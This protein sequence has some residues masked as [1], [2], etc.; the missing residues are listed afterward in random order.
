MSIIC[1]V[2]PYKRNVQVYTK[3]GLEVDMSDITPAVE[4]VYLKVYRANGYVPVNP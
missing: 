2:C 1:N 3:H 4:E